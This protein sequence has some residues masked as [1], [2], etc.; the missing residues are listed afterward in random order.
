MSVTS[1]NWTPCSWNKNDCACDRTCFLSYFLN[2]CVM[3]GF[4]NET[5]NYCNTN[6]SDNWT[7]MTLNEI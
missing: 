2:S 7:W 3:I 5:L 4:A 6:R 1:N